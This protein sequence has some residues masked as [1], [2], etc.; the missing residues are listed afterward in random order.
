MME[1]SKKS[2]EIS[3]LQHPWRC[4]LPNTSRT[5]LSVLAYYHPHPPHP[6]SSITA[7]LEC[8]Q[9]FL[10]QIN[11]YINKHYD[12]HDKHIIFTL[13][14][15]SECYGKKNNPASTDCTHCW[16]WDCVATVKHS[17]SFV[18]TLSPH[19]N[20]VHTHREGFCVVVIAILKKGSSHTVNIL[21][22]DSCL[23]S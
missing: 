16:L 10:V 18:Y 1:K 21:S 2:V 6:S 22:S 17:L 19:C 5:M 8:P 11:V 7:W 4:F 15:W 9:L 20:P 14:C 12:S 3:K 13:S 23:I